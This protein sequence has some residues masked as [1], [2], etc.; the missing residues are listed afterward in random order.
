MEEHNPWP[1]GVWGVFAYLAMFLAFAVVPPA[2]GRLRSF[3]V[4]GR[5]GGG[6]ALVALTLAYTNEHGQHLLL[7]PLF[8]PSDALWLRHSW[9]GILGLIGWAYLVSAALYL[10]I[11]RRREWLVGATGLLMLLYVADHADIATRLA[12][13]EWLDDVRPWIAALQTLFGWIN[14]HVSFGGALGSLAAIAM[15]G[16]CLGSILVPRSEVR[17]EPERL[18]WAGIFGVGLLI[19]ALLFDP[20]Y[21][22]NKIQATPAWCFLSAAIA[23]FGWIFLYWWMDVRSHRAWS[24]AIRPAGANPLLAYL[25][26]PFLYLMAGLIGLRIDF[27]RS[28]AWPLAV[29]LAGCLL[30]ALLVVRLTGFIA[31]AGF[32]IKA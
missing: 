4:I 31:R 5:W 9:W 7:G 6:I 11:G 14:A 32:R 22:L 29:N 27:Y 8:D 12:N 21:G 26:H 23:T 28:S 13:R 1:R 25:L 30:M 15:S 24:G 20:T 18:R 2:P 3:L 16:C 19:A 10:F 17:T